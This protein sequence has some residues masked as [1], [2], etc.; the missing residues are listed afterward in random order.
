[1]FGYLAILL[2]LAELRCGDVEAAMKAVRNAGPDLSDTHT[3]L[4][5]I[6]NYYGDK[7]CKS[8]YITN[9]NA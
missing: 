9:Y 3:L 4:K 2:K 6:H 1:M 5:T 7:S 8:L